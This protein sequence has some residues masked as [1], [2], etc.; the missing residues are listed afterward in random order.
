[1]VFGGVVQQ[2]GNCLIFVAAMFDYESGYGHQV[3][4]IG[5]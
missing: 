5:N 3:R 1:L 2:G 4:D